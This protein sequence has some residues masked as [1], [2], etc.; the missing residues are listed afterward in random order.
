MVL[1]S[2]SCKPESLLFPEDAG[3]CLGPSLGLF[4]AETS[5]S[6]TLG[7]HE[8]N[9]T[10]VVFKLLKALLCGFGDDLSALNL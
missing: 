2:L 6:L 4:S 10:I 1:F 5:L 8:K 7:P 9:E 3:N